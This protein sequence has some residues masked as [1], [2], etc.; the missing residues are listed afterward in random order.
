M[1][2][3]LEIKTPI[4]DSAE[5]FTRLRKAMAAEHIH[6]EWQKV[7][8]HITAVFINNDNPV[9]ELTETFDR[10]L[11]NQ[12][13]LE[14]TFDKVDVFKTRSGS[15]YIVNLTATQPSKEFSSFIDTLREEARKVGAEID[16][17]FIL[18]ITLGR[19]GIEESGNALNQL[20]RITDAI[21]VPPFTLSLNEMKYRYY[22]GDSIR[23]W[24][25]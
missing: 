5:W 3:Y 8:F 12:A 24:T 6:V 18:H 10:I 14:L 4:R 7:P 15:E 1:S 11:D 16:S 20:K 17:D 21:H 2:N 13:A 25:L 9:P 19:I 23:R 22:K